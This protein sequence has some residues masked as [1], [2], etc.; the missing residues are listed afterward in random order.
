MIYRN[1]PL[2]YLICF[3]I[4]NLKFTIS[5]FSIKF[6]YFKIE[7]LDNSSFICPIE[8]ANLKPIDLHENINQEEFKTR[9]DGF[10]RVTY[11]WFNE[12]CQHLKYVKKKLFSATTKLSQV[13]WSFYSRHI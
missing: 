7:E 5:K 3:K 8:N 6:Q 9:L 4:I 2:R 11:I 12:T 10:I 13:D 1:S